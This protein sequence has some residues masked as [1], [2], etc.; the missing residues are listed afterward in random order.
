MLPHVP[1]QLPHMTRLKPTR[2]TPQNHLSIGLFRYTFLSTWHTPD[3]TAPM[4][5]LSASFFC[6]EERRTPRAHVSNHQRRTPVHKLVTNTRMPKLSHHRRKPQAT[7]F[8][9]DKHRKTEQQKSTAALHL[10]SLLQSRW[11]MHTASLAPQPTLSDPSNR[12]QPSSP[13]TLPPW[14]ETTSATNNMI[15]ELITPDS[16]SALLHP[17]HLGPTSTPFV[18]TI[19]PAPDIHEHFMIQKGYGTL[20]TTLK[21]IFDNPE[22]TVT[23]CNERHNAHRRDHC[24]ILSTPRTVFRCIALMCSYVTLAQGLA[25]SFHLI[26]SMHVHVVV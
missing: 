16:L 7:R 10:F 25:V 4:T 9:V 5:W 3:T 23:N 20:C 18:N 21:H 19:H 26:P 8:T 2:P 17:P 24:A 1:L 12:I 13:P 22:T 15:K 11:G 14:N 6:S